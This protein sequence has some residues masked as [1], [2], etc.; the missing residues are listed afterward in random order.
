[1][2]LRRLRTD[3]LSSTE[4]RAI[5]TMLEAA[6]GPDEEERLRDDDWEHG[7]GGV[8]FVLDIDGE[9]VS[10]G[11]VVERRLHVAERPLRTGYVEGVGTEP[12]HQGRGYGSQVMTAIAAH[13]RDRFELGA[14][15]TGRMSFYERLGWLRWIGPTFVKA[16]E[17]MRPTPGEDGYILVLPTPNGPAID[18]SVA[19]SCDWRPGDVW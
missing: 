18:R 2:R 9:I 8:H 3:E 11:S 16:A 5:R 13:I 17:G 12:A 14:L 6:F 15:G 10:H 7:L 19:L 4:S 1:M